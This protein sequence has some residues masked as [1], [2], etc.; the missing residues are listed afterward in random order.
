V[1]SLYPGKGL[2]TI[3]S[4][5]ELRQQ[6]V[7]DIVGGTIDEIA[8]WRDRG[9]PANVHF[10]GHVPHSEL[11]C[12]FS[13][14]HVALLPIL[15]NVSVDFRNSDIGRW[16]SPL[17]LFEYMAHD[18]PIIASDRPTIR[19][20]LTDGETGFLVPPGD[21]TAW[22]RTLDRALEDYPTSLSVG[23]R[24]GALLREKYTWKVRAQLVLS[25]LL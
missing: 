22:A 11:A 5:A 24:A 25:G 1:G 10:H 6:Y 13:S 14:F 16:T 23:K 20:V 3:I 8:W 21:T 17:K 15:P 2:E 12:F 7:F 18:L 19:E 4:L 9:A